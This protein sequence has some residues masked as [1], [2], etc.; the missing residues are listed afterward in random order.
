MRCCGRIDDSQSLPLS[1]ILT[2]S[3]P[4][5][6]HTIYS[7]FVP[8]WRNYRTWTSPLATRSACGVRGDIHPPFGVVGRA[9][10]GAATLDSTHPCIHLR[11]E[12]AAV[13]AMPNGS[14][15]GTMRA[16]S[17]RIAGSAFRGARTFSPG[18]AT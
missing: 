4:R 16:T 10:Q 17:H 2:E 12:A 18:S 8:T 3:I 7:G 13:N 15:Q 9:G 11:A 6:C 14:R 5:F 1:L